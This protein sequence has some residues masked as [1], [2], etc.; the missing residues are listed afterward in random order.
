MEKESFNGRWFG[1]DRKGDR[2]KEWVAFR[3]GE[4]C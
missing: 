2:L 1:A 4:S 3:K